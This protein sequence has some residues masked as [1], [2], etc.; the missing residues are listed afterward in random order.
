MSANLRLRISAQSGAATAG[1]LATL[2]LAMALGGC[3]TGD[4]QRTGDT[5]MSPAGSCDQQHEEAIQ[6]CQLSWDPE[7]DQDQL[8]ACLARA[9]GEFEACRTR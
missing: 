8:Q 9:N 7:A 6:E 5:A 4:D 3:A 2:A 1:L